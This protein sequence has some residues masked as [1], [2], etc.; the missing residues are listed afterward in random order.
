MLLCFCVHVLLFIKFIS[1]YSCAAYIIDDGNQLQ[2]KNTTHKNIA[3]ASKLSFF[4][5]HFHSAGYVGQRPIRELQ[6]FRL[7]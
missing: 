5:L 3:T 4:Y 1:E 7:W 6:N 2:Q